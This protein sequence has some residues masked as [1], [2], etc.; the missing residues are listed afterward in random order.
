MSGEFKALTIQL[1]RT[2]DGSPTCSRDATTRE[3]YC[4]FLGSQKFGQE[5]V[6]MCSGVRLRQYESGYLKPAEECL[7]WHR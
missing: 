7:L 2:P 4:E 3:G 6:C 1:H 5:F